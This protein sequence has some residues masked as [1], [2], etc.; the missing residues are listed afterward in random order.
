MIQRNKEYKDAKVEC[1]LYVQINKPK[2]N[3][4][5]QAMQRTTEAKRTTLGE[6]WKVIDTKMTQLMQTKK[7]KKK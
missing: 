7:E 6:E 2:M 1:N 3:I 4:I 5:K